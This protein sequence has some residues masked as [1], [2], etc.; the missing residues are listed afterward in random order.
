MDRLGGPDTQH[1]NTAEI[2]PFCLWW[3]KEDKSVRISR[4]HKARRT[5]RDRQPEGIPD[6]AQHRPGAEQ[7]ADGIIHIEP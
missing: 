7:M 5:D 1:G 3:N 6:E 2:Q 4:L